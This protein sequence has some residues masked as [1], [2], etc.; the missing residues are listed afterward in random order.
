MSQNT[1]AYP[2]AM[3]FLPS[4]KEGRWEK[5]GQLKTFTQKQIEQSCILSIFRVTFCFYKEAPFFPLPYRLADGVILYPKVGSGYYMRDDLLAAIA[6][7]KKFK[8]SVS[9]AL[10]IDEAN[11]FH[12]A[13]DAGCPFVP[14]SDAYMRRIEF[15]KKDPKGPEQLALKLMINSVYGK[16]AEKKFRGID[17]KTGEPI[18]P[19]QTAL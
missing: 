16:L 15:D 12:P 14:I 10:I 2:Y 4:M 6:W 3:Q 19:P 8:V 18:I 7:C 17:P 13:K 1:S 11:F 9:K 5:T